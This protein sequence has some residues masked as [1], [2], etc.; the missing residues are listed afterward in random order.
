MKMLRRGKK[1]TR[2][3]MKIMLTTIVIMFILRVKA[4]TLMR[5]K[6]VFTIGKILTKEVLQIFHSPQLYLV[7]QMLS[8]EEKVITRTVRKKIKTAPRLFYMS[9]GVMQELAALEELAPV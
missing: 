2:M 1:I 4:K 5:M 9:G 8:Q 6:T 3:Q 7:Y